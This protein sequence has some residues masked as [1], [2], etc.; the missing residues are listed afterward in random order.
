[1]KRFLIAAILLIAAIIYVNFLSSVQ[2]VPLLH[3]LDDFPKQLGQFTMVAEQ[4]FSD[5]VMNSL[6]VDHYIMREYQDK[7]GYPLWLYIGYYESQT[8]GEII[9]SPK[10]CM[11]GS[12][13]NAIQTEKISVPAPGDKNSSYT[14]NQMLL[15]KGI[16][17]QLAHYWYH[18]RGR[19]VADEYW[20]RAYMIL[21][22]ILKRRSDGALVRITGP[23]NNLSAD[24]DNQKA[25]VTDLLNNID[26][27]LPK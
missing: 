7:A 9:H 12:G 17:K 20:D 13:W 24:I 11:P 22:S 6:G 10:H 5:S 1:M 21:D 27:Y 8:E 23:G 16:D 25:F 26:L 14:I 18:S 15:Q 3:S 19:V 4:N 2:A